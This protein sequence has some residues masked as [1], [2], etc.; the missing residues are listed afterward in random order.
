M[1]E[2]CRLDNQDSHLSP[3]HAFHYGS[4][5][6]GHCLPPCQHEFRDAAAFAAFDRREKGSNSSL[7]LSLH[8][9]QIFSASTRTQ[10]QSRTHLACLP[11]GRGVNVTGP[12]FCLP[13]GNGQ[14]HDGVPRLLLLRHGPPHPEV[15]RYPQGSPLFNLNRCACVSARS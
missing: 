14:V 5:W 6:P 9:W 10:G 8:S 3:N 4:A 2:R 1:V 7:H 13:H 15:V 12:V 11:R